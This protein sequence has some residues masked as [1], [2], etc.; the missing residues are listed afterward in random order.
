MDRPHPD[1]EEPQEVRP[2][3][4]DTETI[5]GQG[6]PLILHSK[7]L[8]MNLTT[9]ALLLRYA[10]F[11]ILLALLVTL[12]ASIPVLALAVLFVVA[13]AAQILDGSTMLRALWRG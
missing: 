12:G 7:E 8:I 10:A 3:L 9:V 2:L 6:L 4:L 5:Q 13:T 11:A 1:V